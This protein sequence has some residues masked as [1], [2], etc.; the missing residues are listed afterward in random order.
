MQRRCGAAGGNTRR[1]STVRTGFGSPAGVARPR[2]VAPQLCAP[3]F[4]RVCRFV[5]QIRR[6]S[7]RIT[8]FLRVID[9]QKRRPHRREATLISCAHITPSVALI[10]MTY[11]TT[12][13]TFSHRVTAI[14]KGTSRTFRNARGT[15][16]TDRIRACYPSQRCECHR[17]TGASHRRICA[18]LHPCRV[19]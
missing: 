15:T 12:P 9:S 16:V 7:R 11:I 5:V 18:S 19:A 14:T 2:A 6:T 10:T 3:G 8:E 13:Q 17:M 1:T 4:L